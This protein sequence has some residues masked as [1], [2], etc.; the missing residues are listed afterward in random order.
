M[1]APGS[2]LADFRAAVRLLHAASDRVVV[3][4]LVLALLL[5]VASG[6]LGALA[7]LALKALVDEYSTPKEL[8]R[9]SILAPH[10]RCTWWVPMSRR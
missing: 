6:L 10:H 3:S 5:V 8:L 9:H 4:H 2:N 1:S 7:P